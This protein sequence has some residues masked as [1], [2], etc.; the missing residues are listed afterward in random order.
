M[1]SENIKITALELAVRQILELDDQVEGFLK[2]PME[3]TGKV[4]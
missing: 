1:K 2:N 3:K 4:T